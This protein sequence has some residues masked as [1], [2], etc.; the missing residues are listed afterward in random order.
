MYNPDL[1]LI[2]SLSGPI[3][4]I[5]APLYVPLAGSMCVGGSGFGGGQKGGA[6]ISAFRCFQNLPS[7]FFKVALNKKCL[8]DQEVK[9]HFPHMKTHWKV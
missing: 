4:Q 2:Y 1:F 7:D 5:G 3:Q 8:G 6:W 9:V